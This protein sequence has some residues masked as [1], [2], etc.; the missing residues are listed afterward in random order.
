MV[1]WCTAL[2]SRSFE[3]GRVSRGVIHEPYTC[4]ESDASLSWQCGSTNW[5]KCRRMEKIWSSTC[6]WKCSLSKVRDNP[7]KVVFHGCTALD[8]DGFR[9]ECGGP[10]LDFAQ[11]ITTTRIVISMSTDKAVKSD[12]TC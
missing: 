6:L 11:K 8:G 7:G 9:M 5:E 12:M 1:C 3:M 4:A 2:F 10:V